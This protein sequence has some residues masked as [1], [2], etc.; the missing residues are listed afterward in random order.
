MLTINTVRQ[1]FTKFARAVWEMM[2]SCLGDQVLINK[3]SIGIN[4]LNLSLKKACVMNQLTDRI[5]LTI[6]AN[7]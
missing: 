1:I 2:K 3:V 4:L 7:C 6:F 5:M